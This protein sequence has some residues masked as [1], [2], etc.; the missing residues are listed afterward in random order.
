[1]SYTD[2]STQT[3]PRGTQEALD[4]TS[5]RVASGPLGSTLPMPEHPGDSDH[6]VI[7][8]SPGQTLT[9]SPDL[10]APSYS[11]GGESPV[12]EAA[13]KGDIT[14]LVRKLIATVHPAHRDLP[15]SLWTY[16]TCVFPLNFRTH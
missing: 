9:P 8:G 7:S 3:E 1:M 11:P 14:S 4:P 2:A 13:S 6:D 15:F 5:F 16:V 12:F 10:V